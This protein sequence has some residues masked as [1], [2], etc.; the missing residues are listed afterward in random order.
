MELQSGQTGYRAKLDL[1]HRLVPLANVLRHQNP[2]LHA[3]YRA[4][5]T[6]LTW[7]SLDSDLR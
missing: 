1:G 2:F 4:V 6:R 7:K 3:L 5:C